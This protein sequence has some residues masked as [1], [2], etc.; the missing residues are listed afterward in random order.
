MCV[1][2][3]EYVKRGTR[4]ATSLC[5]RRE[6]L[7]VSSGVVLPFCRARGSGGLVWLLSLALVVPAVPSVL[8]TRASAAP[9][10]AP[11][12][13]EAE[14][15]RHF[16]IGLKL[17]KEKLYEAALTEFEQ[18]YEIVPRPARCATL[19][20]ATA[21]QAHGRRLRRVRQAPL[22][23][24]DALAEEKDAVQKALKELENVT[25]TLTLTVSP[26]G[27]TILVDGKKVGESRSR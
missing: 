15:K 4:T 8:A 14:A 22:R 17:Y 3:G 16:D 7:F 20:S 10:P 19:P 2:S 1:S 25:G 21:S 27:A 24:R 5:A 6:G 9:A 13:A 11:S 12:N 26:D 18:S 23:A